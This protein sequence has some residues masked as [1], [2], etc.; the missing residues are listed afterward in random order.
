MILYDWSRWFSTAKPAEQATSDAGLIPARTRHPAEI[1]AV[2]FRKADG[3]LGGI[4]RIF[5]FRITSGRFNNHEVNYRVKAAKPGRIKPL[6]D[7]VVPDRHERADLIPNRD[8]RVWQKALKGRPATIV[9]DMYKEYN[10]VA[11]ILP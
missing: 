1:V 7:V 8:A 2:S 6:L 10:F 5:T 3:T 9:V 4:D 11:D